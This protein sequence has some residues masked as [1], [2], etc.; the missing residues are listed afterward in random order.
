MLSNQIS[1]VTVPANILVAPVIAPITILGFLAAIL[2]P[3]I[4][5]LSTFL[6]GIATPFAHWIVFISNA[7]AATPVV[8]FN[9]S[10][11]FIFLIAIL[12]YAFCKGKQ[13]IIE[14][15]SLWLARKQLAGGQL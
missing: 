12:A 15:E 1:L 14:F 13:F 4:P 9:R 7:M 3:A 8:S 5:L 2:A 11:T 10:I 6:I